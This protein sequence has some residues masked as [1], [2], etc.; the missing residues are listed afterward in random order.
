M[1]W[2]MNKPG[3]ELPGTEYELQITSKKKHAKMRKQCAEE[4]LLKLPRYLQKELI[5]QR[6]RG[7]QT[8]GQRTGMEATSQRWTGC[9]PKTKK[10]TLA[11]K[12]TTDSR[13][14]NSRF[15]GFKAVV[16]EKHQILR[17]S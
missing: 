11:I 1:N 8:E 4:L 14:G 10:S 2:H 5:L 9:R 17:K 16:W 15:T 3:T 13:H 7:F 12:K 6:T